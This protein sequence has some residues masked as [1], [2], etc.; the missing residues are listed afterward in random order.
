ELCAACPELLSQLKQHLQDV[1]AMEQFLQDS[2]GRSTPPLKAT[3]TTADSTPS[4][5]P[6]GA[7][8]LLAGVTHPPLAPA[9]Q[10]A[11]L[12]RLGG[13]RLLQVLGKGGMGIVYL[14]EDPSLQ[15]HIALKVMRGEVAESPQA[16]QRFLREARAVAALK[17]DHIVTIYQV[18][19]D[20][21]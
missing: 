16:R 17:D 6:A 1:A 15:R 19:E 21:A 13:Y 10:E 9:Q 12:G 11:E 2:A 14:A 7:Q 18:G 5:D 8:P 20:Q 3:L 4:P